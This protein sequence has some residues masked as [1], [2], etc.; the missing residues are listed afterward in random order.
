MM[1]F[2]ETF[3]YTDVRSCQVFPRRLRCQHAVPYGCASKKGVHR[4]S[5]PCLREWAAAFL[6]IASGVPPALAARECLL[7]L[8]RPETVSIWLN[9]WEAE[10]AVEEKK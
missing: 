7:R 3:H 6:L 5:A 2:E 8:R 1:D 4:N 9:R 10:G